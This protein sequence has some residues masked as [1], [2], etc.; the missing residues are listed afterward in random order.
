MPHRIDMNRLTSPRVRLLAMAALASGI[1]M[2]GCG[3]GSSNP[4]AAATGGARTAPSGVGGGGSAQIQQG[5][6]AFAKCMRANG[7]P[8]FPDPSPG[9]GFAFHPGAGFD[10]SSPAVGAAQAKCQKLMPG[11]GPPGPG[12]Q[13]H[14]SAATMARFR[15]IARCMRSH[16]VPQFP[17]PRTSVPSNASPGSGIAEISD[18]EEV[19]FLFPETIDQSSPAFTQAAAACKFP[20]HNH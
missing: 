10:P 20:L 8:K 5:A 1:L 18:I 7:V 14:P 12:T 11:G 9:G 6:L 3:G 2:A 4:P 13:T 15:G 17:D 19:I 16:G